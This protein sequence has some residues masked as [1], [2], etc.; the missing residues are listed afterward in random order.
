MPKYGTNEFDPVFSPILK[1]GQNEEDLRAKSECIL[2]W[3]PILFTF[4]HLRTYQNRVI[5]IIQNLRYTLRK[6]NQ[7]RNLRSRGQVRR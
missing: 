7:G 5:Q 2:A 4:S 1:S 3:H 6:F